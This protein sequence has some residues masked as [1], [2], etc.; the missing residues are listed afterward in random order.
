[1]HNCRHTQK[2][3]EVYL[4]NVTGRGFDYN[5]AFVLLTNEQGEEFAEYGFYSNGGGDPIELDG[6]K[7]TYVDTVEDYDEAEDLHLPMIYDERLKLID[8]WSP[9]CGPC[10]QLS[11]I[12]NQLAKEYPIKLE[13]VNIEIDPIDNY[14]V[15]NVP[16]VIFYKQNKEVDRFTGFRTKNDIIKYIEKYI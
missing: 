14:Q 2:L 12:L 13:E 10:K 1:M 8:I 9:T 6:H 5:L 7:Y 3:W 4:S 11:P 16:T 15:R